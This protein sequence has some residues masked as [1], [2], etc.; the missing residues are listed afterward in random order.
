MV[1]Y[2]KTTRCLRSYLLDYFGEHH[3]GGC[4]NC[5]NCTG[6]FV[7]TDIT[8]EA[9]KILSGVARIQKRWPGGLGVVALVQMLR[10]AKDQKT[11]ERGLDQFP[12]YGI[13]RDVPPQRHAPL[14]GCIAGAGL[15]GRNRR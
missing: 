11:L 3:T 5:S 10:G 6:E 14:P 9:Q 12:T 2:C 7:Q 1:G 4:G 15:P 8:T 13:M